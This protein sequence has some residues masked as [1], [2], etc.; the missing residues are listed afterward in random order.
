MEIMDCFV[1]SSCYDGATPDNDP[2]RV[3]ER[4][5]PREEITI[6]VLLKPRRPFSGK[7]PAVSLER[8]LQTCA[9]PWAR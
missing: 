5:Q 2:L 4:D 9:R 8:A 3:H 7:Q 6:S 1:E